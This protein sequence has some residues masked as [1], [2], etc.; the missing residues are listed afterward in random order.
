MSSFALRLIALV[1]MCIDHMGLALF[2]SASVFRCV[3]RLAFPLYCF[4]LAQGYAHTHDLRAYARRLLLLAFLSEIPFDMLIF[5]RI[6]SGM[7]QNVVFSLL[8]GLLALYALD[9]LAG[10]PLESALVGITLCMLAMVARVSYGWLGIALCLAFRQAG[11]RRAMGAVCAV[12]LSLLYSLSLLFSGVERSWV[13]VSLCAAGAALPL[14]F[15]NGRRG[16]S[17]P[18]LTF[19]FYAAYPLHIALLVL[20]RA[21]R[22]VPPYFL[23]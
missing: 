20:V 6:A 18:V 2:P 10:R 13:L 1:C 19:L 15:Y 16:F 21:L 8:L 23:G 4:L 12:S 9:R 7:E 11:N 17:S 14:L 3:G 5:G 22:I